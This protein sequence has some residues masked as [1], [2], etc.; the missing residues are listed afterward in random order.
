M[1]IRLTSCND[2]A[3]D[4][5]AVTALRGYFDD[6]E[7]A[8]TPFG[9]CFPFLARN[10]QKTREDA[11]RSIYF[12]LRQFVQKRRSATTP[13]SDAIDWLM[14]QGLEDDM[15]TSIVM[16]FTFAAATN[17]SVQCKLASF[18]P[19]SAASNFGVFFSVLAH[20]IPWRIPR[21]EGESHCRVR[22]YDR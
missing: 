14:S 21:M 4:Q 15:I 3:N 5:N 11:N 17:S 19:S 10:Q 12:L 22:S 9:Y 2:L 20:P 13:S 18:C 8:V 1:T 6:V 16:G 7:K